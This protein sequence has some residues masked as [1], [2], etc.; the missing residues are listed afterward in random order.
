MSLPWWKISSLGFCSS[1]E[2]SLCSLFLSPPSISEEFIS[3]SV[4][5]HS[6]IKKLLF[7]VFLG[8]SIFPPTS[9]MNLLQNRVVTSGVHLGPPI[10]LKSSCPSFV[11]LFPTFL[12]LTCL[13]TYAYSAFFPVSLP[14][15]TPMIWYFPYILP[16]DFV[17]SQLYTTFSDDHNNFDN[18]T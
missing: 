18:F 2:Y 4:F 6:W 13:Y 15:R 3:W 12:I 5:P 7:H 14:S 1:L 17:F 10:C 16:G 11:L 9:S 8:S